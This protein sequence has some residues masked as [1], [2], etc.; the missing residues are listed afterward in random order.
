M[1]FINLDHNA[2]TPLH[3][4][5][6]EVMLRCYRNGY[7]NPASLHQAGQQARRVIEE[8]REG[9]A[10][11]LGADLSGPLP[12]RLIFTSGGTEANN[13]AVL[14]IALAQREGPA[15]LIV[16]AIEHPSVLGPAEYLLGHGWRMDT[17]ACGA[18]GVIRSDLL[19]TL[20]SNQTRVVSAMLANHDTG[21][22]QPVAELAR[23]CDEAGIPIHTDAVQVAGKAALNFRALGVSAMSVA[24]HKFGGPVGIGA[25]VLR[26]GIAL[27]ALHF[28]GNQQWGIRPGTE[29][30]ALAVG[31]HT[32]LR[33]SHEN[34]ERQ[35]RRLQSL[36][37]R[38][39]AGLA[40]GFPGL[41]VNG[42]AGPRLPHTSN[43]A[44]PGIDAQILVMALDMAGVACSIGSACS[45]G[46]AELSPTLRAMGLRREI[47]ASSL[48]FSFGTTTTEAEVDEAVRRILDVAG[49]LG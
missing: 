13:L 17:I 6:A 15:Q 12:D 39:E 11:L 27:G 10:A 32:A 46:S 38:F 22:R 34:Q 49:Q 2:T 26:D 35:T 4:E 47:V 44:L 1:D 24:A 40:A 28:G 41:V 3:P 19:P 43:V 48:R 31:M 29:A 14:G 37:D 21:V 42:Q 9:I 20:L 18:D 23:I 8:A 36:R 5:V 30:V 25:L 45:S 7:A 16:S 33:I